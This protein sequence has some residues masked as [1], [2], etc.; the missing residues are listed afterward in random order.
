[1]GNSAPLVVIMWTLWGHLG[2]WIWS[3]FRAFFKLIILLTL[4]KFAFCVLEGNYLGSSLCYCPPYDESVELRLL[5]VSLFQFA[6]LSQER[7]WVERNS[8]AISVAQPPHYNA[9]RRG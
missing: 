8:S 1:M 9:D 4:K 7:V 5:S 3:V 2:V 6:I